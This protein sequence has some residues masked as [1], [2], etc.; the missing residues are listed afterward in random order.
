MTSVPPPLVGWPLLPVPDANGQLN[1]PPLE[2]SIRQMIQVILRTRP[3]EQLMR[4]GFG[5]GLAN[6]LHEPNDLTTYRR[7]HDAI[8]ESL[9]QWEPRIIVDRVDVNE[10]PD[11]PTFLRI[12]I[13]YR[14]RRTNDAQG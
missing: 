2:T 5:A 7:I 14:V 10:V 8:L 12:E 1:Y 13:R 9:Q 3:G 6:F 4:P 11:Q